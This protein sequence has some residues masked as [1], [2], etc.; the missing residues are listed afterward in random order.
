VEPLA[1]VFAVE[2]AGATVL[3]VLVGALCGAVAARLHRNV[4]LGGLSTAAVFIFTLLCLG[5]RILF[6]A[7]IVFAI[8]PLF[9]TFLISILVTRS[10]EFRAV[11]PLGATAAG[12]ACALIGGC[13]VLMTARISLFAPPWVAGIADLGLV[14]VWIRGSK[15]VRLSE[16][17][18]PAGR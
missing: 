14:A 13:A 1:N 18:D 16:Q 8:L 10:L 17:G 11:H 3:A 2:I 15:R 4:F 9:M 12:I 6:V 7:Q 5:G